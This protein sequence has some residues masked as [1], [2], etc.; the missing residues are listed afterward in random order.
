MKETIYHTHH[1]IPRHMGGTDDPEN[2]IRLTVEEHADA[3]KKLYE[4]HGKEEDRIAW[5]G[6][7]AIFSKEEI[8]QATQKLGRRAGGL[9]NKDKP[10]SD[11]HKRNISASIRTMYE[12]TDLA[13][14][15]SESMKGNVNS[16]NHSSEEY[17]KVQSERTKLS[18]KKRKIYARLIQW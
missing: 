15:V 7:A 17:R 9:A 14:K 2:L 16:K 3:H 6:L 13:S 8:V 1:I 11:K 4:Q 12:N 10:K 5:L 18:W